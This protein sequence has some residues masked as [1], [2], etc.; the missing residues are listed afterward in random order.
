MCTHI[1]GPDNAF[2]R[3]DGCQPQ[4]FRLHIPKAVDFVIV[5]CNAALHVGVLVFLPSGGPCCLFS[6]LIGPCQRDTVNVHNSMYF[7]YFHSHRV[8]YSLM[9]R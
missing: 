8:V 6:F 1:N 7:M 3:L 4:Y 9:T 2:F 5:Q